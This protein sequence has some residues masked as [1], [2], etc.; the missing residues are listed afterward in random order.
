MSE[1]LDSFLVCHPTAAYVQLVKTAVS[2]TPWVDKVRIMYLC[3][4]RVVVVRWCVIVVVPV[5]ALVSVIG[6]CGE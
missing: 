2:L 6:A 1:R 3:V 4:K 5:A